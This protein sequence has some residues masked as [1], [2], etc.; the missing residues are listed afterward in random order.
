MK[1]FCKLLLAILLL[2]FMTNFVQASLKKGV[3]IKAKETNYDANNNTITASGDVFIQMDEYTLHAAIVHYDLAR[4]IV[5]AEGNVRI[6]DEKGRRIYGQK[7]VF[8]DKLKKGIIE[9][10]MAKLD[11]NSVIVSRTAKRIERNRVI[12]ERSVFTPCEF[13]TIFVCSVFV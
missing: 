3:I 5:Y 2:G 11:D 10:F 9:E 7:A 8:K 13:L 12:L 1:F 6:I 4:D